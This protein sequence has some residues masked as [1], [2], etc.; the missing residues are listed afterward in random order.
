MLKFQTYDL[1]EVIIKNTKPTLYQRKNI[2]KS[3]SI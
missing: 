1:D 3:F 2:K